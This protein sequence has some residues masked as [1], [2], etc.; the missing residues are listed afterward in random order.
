MP[1]TVDSITGDKNVT[2]MWK[3]KYSDILNNVEDNEDKRALSTRIER[4][5][6]SSINFVSATE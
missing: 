1:Q 3:R 6:R 5:S 2:Q 4:L